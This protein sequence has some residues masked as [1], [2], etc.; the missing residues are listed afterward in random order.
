MDVKVVDGAKADNKDLRS[1]LWG[2]SGHRA[3]YP[4]LFCA[5]LTAAGALPPPP[6]AGS[7]ASCAGARAGEWRFLGT[8][9]TIEPLVENDSD[10]HALTALLA[11]LTREGA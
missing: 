10:E 5:E 11:P 3:V 1:A 4:Q 9:E 8:W 6:A 2:L 7:E